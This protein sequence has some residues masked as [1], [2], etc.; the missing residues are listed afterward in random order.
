MLLFRDINLP[1][2]DV[3]EPQGG[4]AALTEKGCGWNALPKYPRTRI[5]WRNATEL[6]ESSDEATRKNCA[7]S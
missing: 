4:V 5:T 1:R 7:S 2:R 3:S 6:A